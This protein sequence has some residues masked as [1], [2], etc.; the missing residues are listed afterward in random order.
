MLAVLAE[1]E[2]E[3]T[4][5]EPWDTAF[6]LG[7]SLLDEERIVGAPSVLD[8]DRVLVDREI[9]GGVHELAEQRPGGL[10]L[11]PLANPVGEQGLKPS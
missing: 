11:V 4:V 10:V 3:H 1:G 8:G 5:A 2:A 6:L 9:G 7:E